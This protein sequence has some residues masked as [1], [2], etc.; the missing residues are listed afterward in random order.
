MNVSLAAARILALV[1]LATAAGLLVRPGLIQDILRDLRDHPALTFI[2]GL[3]TLAVGG[4]L[5]HSHNLWIAGWPVLITL[6]GWA[7]LAKGVLLLACP[8]LLLDSPLT[9]IINA[10]PRL[11]LLLCALIG[12]ILAACSFC[13]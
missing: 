10:R 2:T 3:G 7:A 6:I 12:A 4:F 8:G 1:Y 9:R 13:A 11:A 5:V